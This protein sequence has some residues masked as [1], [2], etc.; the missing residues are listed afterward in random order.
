MIPAASR[1]VERAGAGTE[2]KPL[3]STFVRSRY[4]LTVGLAYP[5]E[6][7]GG[8]LRAVDCGLGAQGIGHGDQL[9]AWITV[10]GQPRRCNVVRST[11]I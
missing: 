7:L 9:F 8:A 10:R 1:L 5:D 11:Q 6:L 2:R 4:V 3:I